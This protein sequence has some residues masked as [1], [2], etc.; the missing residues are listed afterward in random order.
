MD[1]AH[2]TSGHREM[3]I[4]IL[5]NM[6]VALPD[7]VL[8]MILSKLR[9]CDIVQ[10]TSV[11][12]AWKRIVDGV[13]QEEWRNLYS[14]RI[15][16][17]LLVGKGFNW[18]H[19]TVKATTHTEV[20]DALCMWNLHRVSIV[21]PWKS[22]MLS[23]DPTHRVLYDASLRTD[24]SRCLRNETNFVDFVY[25]N[26]LLLRG[27][28]TTCLQRKAQNLCVNCKKLSRQKCL[29]TA[30]TYY[31]RPVRTMDI[32]EL[33]EYLCGLLGAPDNG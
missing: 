12:V 3:M 13:S 31:I 9:G 11:C 16:S 29:D 22:P 28:V 33:N 32:I 5:R 2:A 17:T 27:K 20:V 6:M 21:S 24:V 19:A 18:C 14:D 26:T 23:Y 10:S 30:Y 15:C 8:W 7:D 1:E 25:G 4:I